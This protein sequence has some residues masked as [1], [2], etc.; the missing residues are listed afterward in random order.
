MER[1]LQVRFPWSTRTTWSAPAYAEH[2][3]G[4][5]NLKN[6]GFDPIRGLDTFAVIN[7]QIES[8]PSIA[9]GVQPKSA[10]MRAFSGAPRGDSATFQRQRPQ[11][12]KWPL[13]ACMKPIETWVAIDSRSDCVRS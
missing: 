1:L 12:F 11:R 10:L 8:R 3:Q 4:G 2:R 7:H 9:L 6:G 5:D 13:S